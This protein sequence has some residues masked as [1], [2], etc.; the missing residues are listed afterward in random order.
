MKTE[1]LKAIPLLAKF[2][3]DELNKLLSRSVAIQCPAFNIVINQ[4]ER[5]QALYL[6]I[7]GRVKVVLIGSSGKEIV[8]SHI[9]EG[10][11]FG[12]LAVFDRMPRSAT[13]ITTQASEFLKIPNKVILDLIAKNSC[14][15][16]KMLEEMSRR[17]RKADAKIEDLALLDIKGRVAKMLIDLTQ[18]E[19]IEKSDDYVVISR[20]KIKD[21]ASRVC[22]S[23]ETVSRILKDFNKKRQIAI[24]KDRIVIFK[25]IDED[26][27]SERNLN[28]I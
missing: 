1:L 23:R 16:I 2:S 20:P 4:D 6:I 3:N 25:S 22:S 11:Y 5:E 27:Y 12:E 7:K 15:A 26:N 8:L 13:I 10:S 19:S 21:I 28:L 17:L 24:T 18:D 14:I 9:G